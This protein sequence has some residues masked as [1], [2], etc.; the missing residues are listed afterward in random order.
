MSSERPHTRP[1]KHIEGRTA[2]LIAPMKVEHKKWGFSTRVYGTI[3]VAVRLFLI[4]ASA[5]V[6]AEKTLGGG[7]SPAQ[8]LVT[9]VPLLAVGV[10]IVTSIDAWLK[11][12]EKW[13]G[14]MEDRDE[15][16]SLIVRGQI[17]QEPPLEKLEQ[18]FKELR[19]RHIERNVF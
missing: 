4:I 6:A 13:R 18:E 2:A 19:S 11:P 10:T 5:I 17:S 7:N 1:P 16:E 15:L 9:W 3:N 8:F 14:F 12:H